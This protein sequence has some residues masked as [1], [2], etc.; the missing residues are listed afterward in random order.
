[1]SELYQ[2][3]DSP[4]WWYSVNIDGVRLRGSTKRKSRSEAK[5]VLAEVLQAEASKR[6]RSD[7]WRLRDCLG[8]YWQEH[9]KHMPETSGIFGK[10]DALSRHLGKDTMIEDLTN[11]DMLDYRARRVAEGLQPHSVNRDFSYL[12]AALKWAEVMHGKDTPKLAWKHIRAKEPS[13][14]IRFLSHQE[15]HQLLEVCSDDLALI[16]K[17]AVAT[18]LRKNT[19]LTLDWSQVDLGGRR[20]SVVGKGDKRHVVKLPPP[21]RA[22]LSALPYDREEGRKGLVFNITNFRK[23]FE[24]AVRQ[25][26]LEDFRFHDLR[27]TCATWMR[28]AGADL[29]DI[30]EALNHSSIAVTMRYAHIEPE[31]YESAFDRISERVWSRNESR[32]EEPRKKA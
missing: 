31:T 22:A 10:L 2:R 1:M 21:L 6:R 25:A 24:G 32:N 23:R 16:I 11:A 29:I 15:Y 27:H 8:A 5:R 3:E 18:G 17:F 7:P 26:G 4:F 19:I 30:C 9:A 14:R 28:M 13:H 12:Q 20:V